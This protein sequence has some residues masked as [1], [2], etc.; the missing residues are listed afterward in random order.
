MTNRRP[1]IS[2][3]ELEARGK[4]AI[5]RSSEEVRAEEAMLASQDAAISE[6]QDAR[7]P[8]N[9]QSG[10]SAARE[11]ESSIAQRADNRDSY[12]KVTY[13]I[14]TQALDAIEDAKRLLRRQYGVRVSLEDIA[15]QAILAAYTDLLE[16]QH[17][18]TLVSQFAGNPA[19]Q[20]RT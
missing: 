14:S 6:S 8:A 20:K 5:L 9:Q 18:S 10:T 19:R 15:E 16:N 7:L 3:P 11:L 13:R 4:H 12:T 1:K 17:A 2:F